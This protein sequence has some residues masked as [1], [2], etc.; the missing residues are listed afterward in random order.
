MV[1]V[2][3]A[4]SLVLLPVRITAIYLT[5]WLTRACLPFV[6]NKR[7]GLKSSNHSRRNEG[8]IIIDKYQ[9]RSVKP[10]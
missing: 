10:G 3:A 4:T 8:T 6:L 7:R 5:T 2:F 9:R 1:T